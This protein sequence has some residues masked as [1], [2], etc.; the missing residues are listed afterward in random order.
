MR[1]LPRSRLRA[2][3]AVFTATA[4]AVVVLGPV[5]PA[6]A[7]A[8][9]L[10]ADYQAT[11][12]STSPDSGGYVATITISNS[13]GEAVPD[14]TLRLTLPPDHTFTHGWSAEWTVE[15]G[16]LVATNLPWA[17]WVTIG[18][19]VV[20]GFA[21]TWSGSPQDP[22]NCTINGA[23]CDG[24]PANDEPPT[25]TL[26]Q[27]SGGSAGYVPPCPFVLAAEASDPDGVDRV[28]FYVNGKLVGTDDTF[29][30]RVDIP[31]GS[32][33]S[34]APPSYDYTAIARAYD[35]GSPSLSSESN[36]VNFHIVIGDPPPGIIMACSG[37]RQLPA[38]TSEQARFIVSSPTDDPVTFT[39]TGDPGITVSPTVAAPDNRAVDVTVT[40][41]PGSTGATATITATSG[42]FQP[43][44]LTVTVVPS[45]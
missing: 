30:Y 15:D 1:V 6:A 41:A 40:A 26:T 7:Q 5:A 17:S 10:T 9:C 39:V 23:P 25:V 11:S 3:Q 12:W 27:P 37:S 14:W 8:A 4:V 20:I 22:L 43:G 34:V 44:S 38:G 19:P 32:L 36:P 24:G 42:D 28:E 29:P 18:S 2:G 33:P 16:E 13:C 45:S 21:G 35:A 31:R